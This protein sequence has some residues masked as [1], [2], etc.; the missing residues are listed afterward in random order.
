MSWGNI[1][2]RTPEGLSH[3]SRN[4]TAAYMPRCA[5]RPLRG[6]T[7]IDATDKDAVGFYA[8][9]DFTVTSLGVRS[10][11]SQHT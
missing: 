2:R 8:A 7:A 11:Q 9:N 6:L 3:F 1:E 10:E 5:R 4:E